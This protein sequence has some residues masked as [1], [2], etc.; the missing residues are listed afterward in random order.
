MLSEKIIGNSY[1]YLL[2][3]KTLNTLHHVIIVKMIIR[4][5]LDKED[6]QDIES[7]VSEDRVG[8]VHDFIKY[9]V[10]NQITLEKR[11]IDDNE[12]ETPDQSPSSKE[13]T[14]RKTSRHVPDIDLSVPPDD[15]HPRN[16][17]KREVK[18]R[19]SQP[20]WAISNKF[21]PVKFIL[22]MLQN[23][24]CNKDDNKI[25]VRSFRNILKKKA[26]LVKKELVILDEYLERKRG[27]KIATGFPED[28]SNSFNRF[29]KNLVIV[30][31]SDDEAKGGL[32]YLLGF[33]DYEDG[34]I[35]L[36]RKGCEF[37]NLRS[38]ILDGYLREGDHPEQ[39]FSDEEL[40]FLY[41]HIKERTESEKDLFDFMLRKIKEGKDNTT[42]LKK[43]LGSY[44]KQNYP[45]KEGYSQTS[46]NSLRSGL[47]SRMLEIDLISISRKNRK[48]VYKITEKGEKFLKR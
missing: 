39:K 28:E 30:L 4:V 3:T 16:L 14:K 40:D 34:D 42:D 26:P 38:P 33:V 27:N 47:T 20:I 17:Q 10:Q 5:D 25:D 24:L 1:C 23:E 35:Y 45:K 48:H 41:G 36:A 15:L 29:F 7:F 43:E 37:S 8:S 6:L 32:S 11:G 18:R 31:D 19:T 22:R 21:F 12:I 9:A 2:L 46:V 13:K 44:L